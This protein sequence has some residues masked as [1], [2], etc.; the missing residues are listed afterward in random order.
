M[1]TENSD[2]DRKDGHTYGRTNKLTKYVGYLIEIIKFE[3]CLLWEVL[4]VWV[5]IFIHWHDPSSWWCWRRGRSRRR[6]WICCRTWWM[7]CWGRGGD[8]VVEDYL[9]DH[10]KLSSL[11]FVCFEMFRVFSHW[12][13]PSSWW[14][15]LSMNIESVTRDAWAVLLVSWTVLMTEN[16]M[17]PK[18]GYFKNTKAINSSS[19]IFS[20]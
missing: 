12:L 17:R 6:S 11:N 5:N 3:L 8:T 1:G 15:F 18:I 16:H 7:T 9:N 20:T 2:G 14:N 19:G 4:S 10:M 13:D